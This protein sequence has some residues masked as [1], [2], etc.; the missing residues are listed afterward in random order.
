MN[1]DEKAADAI[2]MQI[3][4]MAPSC[5]ET[6]K[7]SSKILADKFPDVIEQYKK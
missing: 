5:Q 4:Q 2:V 1:N 3:T 6:T 7:Q